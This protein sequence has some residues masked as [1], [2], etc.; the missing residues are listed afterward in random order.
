M[1]KIETGKLFYG[2]WTCGHEKGIY[3]IKGKLEK[4]ENGL[5]WIRPK[6]DSVSY[7]CEI[8]TLKPYK[9]KVKQKVKRTKIPCTIFFDYI[10]NRPGMFAT[11]NPDVTD[12]LEIM[13]KKH[14][15]L[16]CTIT[17]ASKYLK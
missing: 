4:I 15:S 11:G 10:P 5:A 9:P 12:T 7:G 14:G 3:P 2:K 6:N 8:S 1:A 13:C 16:P 17:I